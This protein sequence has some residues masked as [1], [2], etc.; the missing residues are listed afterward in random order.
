M[1][2]SD[3]HPN[4]GQIEGVP[5]NPRTITPED[6]ASLKKSLKNFRK[7]LA[8]RPIVV[9][10]NNVILGGNMRYKAL[11]KLAQEKATC[12]DFQFGHDIPDEWVRKA[13]DLTIDE[14]MRFIKEDNQERG[15]WDFDKLA[16]EWEQ[17]KLKDWDAPISNW[18]E[19]ESFVQ[20]ETT[21]DE[22]N[23]QPA[24]IN[25]VEPQRII[26]VYPNE[27]KEELEKFLGISI[28]KPRY[29][30]DELKNNTTEQ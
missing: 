25:E 6:F 29:T 28:T 12:G 21:D 5:S 16:N 10:E 15:Q 14:K 11:C 8:L 18:N 4:E 2:L 17:S 13:T 1:K 3:L 20:D 9:D 30:F 26:I 19:K 23:E 7:M 27:R 24:D 22:A